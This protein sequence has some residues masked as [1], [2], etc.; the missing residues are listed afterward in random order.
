MG[1]STA[2]SEKQLVLDGRDEIKDLIITADLSRAIKRLLDYARNFSSGRGVE[3]EAVVLSAQYHQLR[4]D[5]R[6]GRAAATDPMFSQ[7][8]SSLL[9]LTDEICVHYQSQ[10]SEVLPPPAYNQPSSDSSGDQAQE[11]P[12][13]LI[14]QGTSLDRARE[15]FLQGRH[16]RSSTVSPTPDVVFSCRGLCKSYR[17]RSSTFQLSNIN[18][19]LRTGEITGLVGI[20]GSGKTTLL[21]IIAGELQATSGELHY[22][23]LSPG[24]LDWPRIR[25]QIAYVDQSPPQWYGRL[26]D[27]LHLS[28]AVHGFKGQDNKDEVDFILHRLGLA[29][30][31]DHTWGE[32]SGGYKMRFE[33]AKALVSQPKCLI[34]D[35]PLAPLDIVT[36]QLFLQDLRDLAN[37]V[38]HP[39]PILVSSQHLYEIE[40]IADQIL[41]LND[42]KCLYYGKVG[43]LGNAQEDKLFE[44]S[45]ALSRSE[46]EGILAALPGVSVEEFG[47]SYNGR[48]AKSVTGTDVLCALQNTNVEVTY[49]RD[50]SHSVRR[51]FELKEELL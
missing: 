47:S 13:P 38:R 3:N 7:L 36:Q 21:R 6:L 16:S 15:R 25:S 43:E 23:L 22:P 2:V 9:E 19:V 41:V 35:E 50:I 48:V 37:A 44:L 5:I 33:L 11:S 40:T 30:Y 1:Q 42:G 26:A 34:L 28:A 51:L 10:P 39:L 29:Q 17:K 27:N 20:N 32:I 46:L 4:K 49:F 45:C 12:K 8:T 14:S 31:R 18:L 24:S